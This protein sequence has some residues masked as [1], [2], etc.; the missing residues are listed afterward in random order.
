MTNSLKKIVA[1]VVLMA[2]VMPMSPA[3]A[4][5]TTADLQAQIDA[6]MVTI[7]AL[8]AQLGTVADE[9]PVATISGCSISSFD[10]AMKKGM[11]GDDVKCL[12]IV[13]NSD[14]ETKVASSG[15][16]SSGSETKYFGG[17]TT[18]A[19]IKFQEKYADAV[20]AVYGLTSGTGYV[21]K[22]TRAKLNELL[23]ATPADEPAADEPAADEPVA[24]EPVVTGDGLTVALAADTPVGGT[25]VSGSSATEMARYTFTNG[26]ASDVKV[27][28]LRVKRT[29]ISNDST[30]ASIYVF[31]GYNRLG[32]E[33]T[34]SSG[35]A[36]FNVSGGIFTVPAGGSKTISLRADIAASVSGQTARLSIESA[37]DIVTDA[38]ALNGAFPMN[39]NLM[40]AATASSAAAVTLGTA[41]PSAVSVDAT[42]DFIAWSDT[43]AV[44]NQD[45][46]LE[47]IRFSQ[48]G[49]ISANDIANIR[50]VLGGTELGTSELV[51]ANVGQDLVFDLSAAPIAIS[52]G[53]TKTMQVYADVIS[54]AEKTLRIGLEKKADI[55]I[56]DAAYGSYV[57]VTGTA[58]FRA[59]AQTINVGTVTITKSIT[60]ASGNVVN[61]STNISL[62]KFDIKANGEEVKINSLQI[63][64]VSTDTT[65]VKYLRNVT[66]L[67]DG[68]QVGNTTTVLTNG[69]S[70]YYSTFNIYQKIAAGTTKVLEVRGDVYG[71]AA[72]ACTANTM[73]ATDTVQAKVFGG[74]IDNAQGMSSLSMIDAPGANVVANALTVGEGTLTVAVNP[75]YG[76]QTVA[77]GSNTKIASYVLTAAAYD[78]IN[79]S[80]LKVDLTFTTMEI[81]DLSNMYLVY[82]GTTTT[83]KGS[84]TASNTFSVTTS[85][86]PSATMNVDVYATIS[87]SAESSEDVKTKLT[88]TA[89]KN[90]DGSDA[91]PGISG[92]AQ[93]ISTAAGTITTAASSA[94]PVAGIITGL[95]TGV[96]LAKFSFSAL[97]EA[98]TVSEI[99]I[100][101]AA[102]TANEFQG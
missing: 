4:A 20:L 57:T 81:A 45:V 74:D 75:S 1:T 71:C 80:S 31:D 40:S 29:G 95:S 21:G 48:I 62:G 67:L 53:H 25:I 27:T 46:T 70:P 3:L 51:V 2:S 55:F 82:G 11:S 92:F 88:V 83:A 26:D 37:S 39:G 89:T 97:Y 90:T 73:A 85:M 6:L 56:K 69:T 65:N 32:D 44:T 54:G 100:E 18:A 58:P 66:L 50:L 5:D 99:R 91:S 64:I 93:L 76:N 94:T 101:T 47:Y 68:V 38:S 86:A 10:R 33:A 63:G 102:G 42:T 14:S 7:A 79:I 24:D 22:T 96:E 34:L 60:S 30:L 41:T 36:T 43:L 15:V 9:T 28:Q 87:T 72:S 98:F 49:S 16:G 77:V 12:Q 35:Y 52:K 19:V 61:A 17:L 23:V 78:T 8:Q 84:V 59:G 13:L